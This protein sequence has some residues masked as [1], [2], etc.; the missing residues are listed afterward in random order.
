MFLVCH[1][2]LEPSW[3]F[4]KKLQQ[5]PSLQRPQVATI[6]SLLRR[7]DDI[8]KEKHTQATN[9]EMLEANPI[10]SPTRL[11][12]ASKS[13]TRASLLLK[14]NNKNNNRKKDFQ[15]TGRKRNISLPWGSWTQNGHFLMR[16]RR[17]GTSWRQE[18]WA[19]GPRVNPSSWGHVGDNGICWQNAM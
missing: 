13:L 10:S 14:N 3:S 11:W 4:Q 9:E 19:S 5:S 2:K 18:I 17:E 7:P 6:Q 1:L 8:W 15:I 16:L 12:E